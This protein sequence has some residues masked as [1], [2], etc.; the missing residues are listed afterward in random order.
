MNVEMCTATG[1][2]LVGRRDVRQRVLDDA[3]VVLLVFDTGDANG[4]HNVRQIIDKMADHMRPGANKR[5]PVM[6]L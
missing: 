2:D 4:L 3:R 5:V 6:L 1:A